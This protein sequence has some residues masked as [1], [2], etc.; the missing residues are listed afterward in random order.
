MESVTFYDL[1]PIR[2]PVLSKFEVDFDFCTIQRV[3]PDYF[4]KGWAALFVRFILPGL[5]VW[6]S[7]W[8]LHTKFSKKIET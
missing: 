7:T 6:N 2:C 4:S 8:F 5:P 3:K 1:K